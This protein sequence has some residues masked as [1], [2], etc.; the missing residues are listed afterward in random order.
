MDATLSL[1]ELLEKILTLVA[2]VFHG[3]IFAALI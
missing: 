1:L 2:L 3:L